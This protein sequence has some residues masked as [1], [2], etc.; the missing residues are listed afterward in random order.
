MNPLHEFTLTYNKQSKGLCVF[1]VLSEGRAQSLELFGI[2][3]LCVCLSG[4][5]HAVYESLS[6]EYFSRLSL[7]SVPE[8]VSVVTAAVNSHCNAT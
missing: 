6:D 8:R 4:L 2:F 7:L 3:F 1:G 5:G